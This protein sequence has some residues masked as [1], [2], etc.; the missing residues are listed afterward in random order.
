MRS[1]AGSAG[2][3]ARRILL[4]RRSARYTDAARLAAEICGLPFPA[5]MWSINFVYAGQTGTIPDK[6]TA[7]KSPEAGRTSKLDC[8][9]PL[10]YPT[11]FK[12]A[13]EIASGG[14]GV[15]RG[16]PCIFMPK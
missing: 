12:I 3:R 16:A 11:S 7:G 15:S 10:D 4:T 13:S 1:A 6:I 8:I 9:A 2:C 14:I 5:R